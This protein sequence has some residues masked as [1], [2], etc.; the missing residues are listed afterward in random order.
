MIRRHR[1]DQVKPICVLIA[2]D[3]DFSATLASLRLE[4]FNRVLFIH[5][6][7]IKPAFIS[8]ASK[9]ATWDSICTS[10]RQDLWAKIAA[11]NIDPVP[12]PIASTLTPSEAKDLLSDKITVN[13]YIVALHIKHLQEWGSLIDDTLGDIQ[14]AYNIGIKKKSQVITVASD[15]PIA[16]K[17]ILDRIKSLTDKIVSSTKINSL[18]RWLPQHREAILKSE[19]LLE[20]EKSFETTALFYKSDNN[21]ITVEV[22]SLDKP[23]IRKFLDFIDQLGPSEELVP[24]PPNFKLTELDISAARK[25]YAIKVDYGEDVNAAKWKS[26]PPLKLWGFKYKGLNEKGRKA[27]KE[28]IKIAVLPKE[29]KDSDA[30][31]D[32]TLEY[33]EKHDDQKPQSLFKFKT[34]EAG[35]FYQTYENICRA[36]IQ[37]I[38]GLEVEKLDNLRAKATTNIM[39]TTLSM[40]GN[41]EQL[42]IAKEYLKTFQVSLTHTQVFFPR[43]SMDKYKQLHEMKLVCETVS[44]EVTNPLVEPNIVS[45]RLKVTT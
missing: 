34:R 29:T 14:Y 36:Y 43:V 19:P 15:S 31:S 9:S 33:V 4:G 42:S 6:S 13:Q 27:L 32:S 18:R 28:A 5:N 11:S 45:V 24:T 22:T 35:I 39:Q 3:R 8:L 7:M 10:K 25:S 17:N 12:K 20:A 41:S 23:S 21:Q 44:N 2:G 30:Q 37:S 38:S 26:P 1:Q 40:I 16:L